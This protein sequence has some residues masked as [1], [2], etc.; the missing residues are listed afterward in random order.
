MKISIVIPQLFYDTIARVIPGVIV[1]VLVEAY[2]AIGPDQTAA[3]KPELTSVVEAIGRGA[4]LVIIAYVIGWMLSGLTWPSHEPKHIT[5]ESFSE[6][7]L[8]S[9]DRKPL[10]LRSQYQWI[11]LAHAEAG[12]RIVKLRAEA[13]MLEAIRTA[14]ALSTPVAGLLLLA[15]LLD[16][17]LLFIEASTWRLSVLLFTSLVSTLVIYWRLERKAWDN[18]KGNISRIYKLLHDDEN[19]IPIDSYTQWPPNNYMR[20]TCKDADY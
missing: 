2:G 18:Y 17:D 1:L 14:F 9:H 11:R 16:F 6:N 20:Q 12:F 7:S 4:V 19:P 10:S 15:K 3:I 5:T 13:R 8:D